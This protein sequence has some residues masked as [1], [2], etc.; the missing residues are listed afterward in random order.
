MSKNIKVRYTVSMGLPLGQ[1]IAPG[2]ERSVGAD[3][4]KRLIERGYAIP[5][6]KKPSQ[7]AEKRSGPKKG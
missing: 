3:E 2:E 6:A 1:S 7:R 4:A 5:V